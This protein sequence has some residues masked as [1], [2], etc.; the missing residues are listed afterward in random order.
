MRIWELDLP[1]DSWRSTPLDQYMRGGIT[2]FMFD[3]SSETSLDSIRAF[4]DMVRYRVPKIHL[5]GFL[6]G[7]ERVVTSEEV[8]ALVGDGMKYTEIVN[9]KEGRK[10]GKLLWTIQYDSIAD[11]LNKQSHLTG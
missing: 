3:L 8:N 1:V 7:K 5:I 10:L 6:S 4:V 2:L 11:T 9:D